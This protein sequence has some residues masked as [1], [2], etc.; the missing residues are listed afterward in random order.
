M[1][2]KRTEKFG[3]YYKIGT[4][5]IGMAFI[6]IFTYSMLKITSLSDWSF[7][8]YLYIADK[9]LLITGL[10]INSIPDFL[11]KNIKGMIFDLI[12]ILF[13]L[14]FFVWF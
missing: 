8:K 4:I 14:L 9:F 11:T 5:I 3:R 7:L 12:F 6:C 13:M 2:L 10:V 1:L